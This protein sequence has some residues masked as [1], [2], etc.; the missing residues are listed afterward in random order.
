LELAVSNDGARVYVVTEGASGASDCQL[1]VLDT[2]NNMGNDQISN[3]IIEQSA[4]NDIFLSVAPAPDNR[5]FALLGAKGDVLVWPTNLDSATPQPDPDPSSPVNLGVDLRGLVIGSGAKEAFTTDAGGNVLQRLDIVGMVKGT[6]ISL[7][8]LAPS[9]L[10]LVS[11]TGP[12]M[13]A[14][15]SESNK[16]LYL[17]GLNPD[18]LVGSVSL[19]HDPI[20]LTVSPGGQW[21]YVLEQDTAGSFV[22]AVNLHRMQLPLSPVVGTPFKVG[23]ASQQIVVSDSG[24][25]LYIPFTGDMV[26]PVVGGVAV[27]DVSEQ[28]CEEILWRHLDGCPQCDSPNCVVLATIEHYQIGDKIQDQTDPLADPADGIARIDNRK[29]RQL[30][31]ST[32][33]LKELIECLMEQ[34][35]GGTGTQGPP[36]HQG[37]K[38]DP[39]IDDVSLDMQPCNIPELA[40]IFTD[41]SGKRILKLV[42]PT[43]CDTDL[44]HICAINWVHPQS[45]NNPIDNPANATPISKLA[46][47]V[48]IVF[49][50]PVRKGDIHEHSFIVLER[51][52]T[53]GPEN[54]CW[55]EVLIRRVGGVMFPTPCEIT[56]DFT[57]PSELDKFVNG[58]QLLPNKPFERGKQYRVVLKGDFIRD[59]EDKAVDANHLPPWL[60][61]QPSGDGTEGGT[62]ESWFFIGQ[63]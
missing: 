16:K 60:P 59:K 56:E 63:G 23:D 28:A 22:Q 20:A 50:R 9:E 7:P 14:V 46:K 47:G 21:A 39:G 12:D 33:V 53:E 61:D 15:V 54:R 51:P 57:L 27:L 26:K 18:T 55:C 17:V 52:Q 62:F 42:I 29:G 45:T 48:L 37:D 58:A 13:L 5:L 38:G 44:T 43:N 1:V 2:A 49:D 36:G 31:P 6:A 34:G 40:E 32:Q 25:H 19:D 24:A 3:S 35:P 10:A 4:G 30:L 41:T 8:N 11:S